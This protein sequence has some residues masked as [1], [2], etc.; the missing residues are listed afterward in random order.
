MYSRITWWPRRATFSVRIERFIRSTVTASA[1]TQATNTRGSTLTSC[2]SSSMNAVAVKGAR[3]VPPMS[4]PMLTA[5]HSPGSPPSQ[6]AS[7]AP[8]EP[9]MIKSGASTPPDVPEPR[10]TAHI[11]AFVRRSPSSIA[12]TNRPASKSR[13]VS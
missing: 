2:V 9:P 4:A 10:A 11:S 6:C 12:P 5:A 13:I 1:A 8:S 3:I 7:N